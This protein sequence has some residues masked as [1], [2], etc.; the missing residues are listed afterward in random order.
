MKHS[1]L[2]K[3]KEALEKMSGRYGFALFME[4]GVGKTVTLLADIEQL[5]LAE[6]ISG[7]LV[8]APKGVHTNWVRREIPKHMD[9]NLLSHGWRG[10]TTKTEQKELVA[11]NSKSPDQLKIFAINI[12]ALNAT[13]GHKAAKAFLEAHEGSSYFVVD[14]SSRIKTPNSKRTKKTIA[15][16]RLATY[17]RIA[18]GTPVTLAPPDLFSQ[19]SFLYDDERALRKVL[20]TDSYRS[21]VA[22]FAELLP[23]TDPRMQQIIRNSRYGI[24]Q[25]YARDTQGR[26]IW[27]NLGRLKTLLEPHSFRCLKEECFDLPPKVYKTR[28]FELTP[29]QRRNYAMMEEDNRAVLNGEVHTFEK[30]AALNKLRQITSGFIMVD[31]QPVSYEEDNP[32]MNLFKDM[33]EEVN[34]QLIVWAHYKE[35]IRA[36]ASLLRSKEIPF[37]EYHGDIK[38]EEREKAVDDFQSGKATVFLGNAQAGGTGLTLTAATEVIYFS[39]DFR[40]ENRVQSEDRCH[41]YGTTKTVVYTDLVAPNTRDEAI[42][43]SRQHKASTAETIMGDKERLLVNT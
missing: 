15:L 41:R 34:G 13:K 26:P 23:P 20:G 30:L 31:G 28:Y 17:R 5:F 22:T 39:D 29:Q 6:K 32:R 9:I 38:D 14:E 3:Q 18:T 24:P 12:D 25:V 42:L 27:K 16:G 2:S 10:G 8:V 40:W 35:E 43:L 21:F 11:L 1:L 7:V 19:F 33:I 4:Q 37:V 36:I